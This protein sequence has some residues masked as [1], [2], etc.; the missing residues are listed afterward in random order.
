MTATQTTIDRTHYRAAREACR[1]QEPD[2]FFASHF[3]PARDRPAVMIARAVVRQIVEIVDPDAKAQASA[4]TEESTDQRAKPRAE[5]P[6]GRAAGETASGGCAAC[7]GG[8]SPEQRRA[9]CA[10]VLDFL[11]SGQKTGKPE[12]DGF[13]AVAA[14]YGLPREYFDRI[15]NGLSAF[16]TTRRFAT[17]NR[18]RQTVAVFAEAEAALAFSVLRA[19]RDPLT[20]TAA[21]QL[22][23]WATALNIAARLP[24]VGTYW[25]RG[26]LVLPLEDLVKHGLAEGGIDGVLRCNEDRRLVEPRLDPRWVALMKH[27][28]DRV[29]TLHR[30]GAGW[31]QSLTPAGAR[32]AAVFSDGIFARLERFEES[33]FAPA[34][35]ASDPRASLWS[36]LA[37]VPR[38]MS[39]AGRRRKPTVA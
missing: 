29:R 3:L 31:L 16:L 32:A 7:G 38:A 37:R 20:G 1:A 19:S 23:A 30:G 35:I 28:C 6:P 33:G 27:E 22:S 9:V 14:A 17:W 13:H 36:R 25:K 8:E 2:A 24:H 4:C 12:L 18:L 5:N 39:G 10:A 26:R 11:Y 15:A 21:A 34:R